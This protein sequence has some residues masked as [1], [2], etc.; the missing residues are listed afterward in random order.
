MVP[1]HALLCARYIEVCWLVR[2]L[3]S[4]GFCFWILWSGKSRGGVLM[5]F[6]SEIPARTTE[7]RVPCFSTDSSQLEITVRDPG[8]GRT[9]L[10]WR[11]TDESD[12]SLLVPSSIWFSLLKRCAG[13]RSVRRCVLWQ[14]CDRAGL[15]NL[16]FMQTYVHETNLILH[17][18][19]YL[20]DHA[21]TLHDMVRSDRSDTWFC[22]IHYCV[23]GISKS[24]DRSVTCSAWDSV[25]GFFDQGKEVDLIAW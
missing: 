20:L 13:R 23:R 24:A 3:L 17:F 25:F 16:G 6:D 11:P 18:L 5:D 8:R 15:S 22:K 21:N 19:G 9:E 2:D 14:R 12:E 1:Q 10:H 7:V 4:L